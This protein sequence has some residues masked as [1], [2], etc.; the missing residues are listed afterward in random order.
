MFLLTLRQTSGTVLFAYLCLA[1]ASLGMPALATPQTDSLNTTSDLNGLVANKQYPELEQA[2][3]TNT[4][5]L[6]PQSRAYFEGILA[7]RLNLAQ[8]SIELLEPLIPKLLINNLVRG[9]VALCAVAELS[10]CRCSP[11][12]CRGESNCETKPY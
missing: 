1:V 6:P 3:A 2:L 10:L 12:L 7:N 4:A 9:E 8:K 5:E 11:D